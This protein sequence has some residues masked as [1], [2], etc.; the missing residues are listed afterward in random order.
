M[1]K[2]IICLEVIN[3]WINDNYSPT[4]VELSIL[5]DIVRD[6]RCLTSSPHISGE[7]CPNKIVEDLVDIMELFDYKISISPKKLKEVTD[8]RRLG[9]NKISPM[10]KKILCQFRHKP[11]WKP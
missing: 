9:I 8:K 10:Q 4:Y 5:K 7:R 11:S 3:A 1:N 6:R 2:N